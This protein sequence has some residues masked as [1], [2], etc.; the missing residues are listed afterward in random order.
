M[1]DVIDFGM[2]EEFFLLVNELIDI[3][4]I[5]NI[6]NCEYVYLKGELLLIRTG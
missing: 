1:M 3:S 6:S 2:S 5:A 4:K